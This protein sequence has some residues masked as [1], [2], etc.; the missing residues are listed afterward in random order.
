[1][2]VLD[3][4]VVV[5]KII[6]VK[7]R[8]FQYTKPNI[9]WSV[10]YKCLTLHCTTVKQSVIGI[11]RQKLDFATRLRKTAASVIKST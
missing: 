2:R 10:Q 5:M 9:N 3:F 11:P 1:M 4:H 7:F 8:K 6:H